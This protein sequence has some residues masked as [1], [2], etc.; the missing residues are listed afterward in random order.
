L[1]QKVKSQGDMMEALL[2]DRDQVVAENQNL[3]IM[4]QEV[5][6]KFKSRMGNMQSHINELEEYVSQNEGLK[7]KI[8]QVQKESMEEINSLTQNEILT[9]KVQDLERRLVL[10]EDKVRSQSEILESTR[11]LHKYDVQAKREKRDDLRKEKEVL[12]LTDQQRLFQD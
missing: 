7:A 4:I 11:Y 2:K 6:D 10:C 9:R 3:K 5:E 8:Q 1:D 12:A